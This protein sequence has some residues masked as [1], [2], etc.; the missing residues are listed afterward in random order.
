[1]FKLYTEE[2][3]TF[4]FQDYA[5]LMQQVKDLG[6]KSCLEF[7]PGY[8]TYALIEAGLDLIVTLE[9]DPEWYEISVRRFKEYPQVWVGHYQDEPEVT[10]DDLKP[11]DFDMAFVDS[12]KGNTFKVVGKDGQ[13]LPGIRKRHPG[14]EDCSR[15]N[16]CVKALEH[17]PVV[18]LHDAQR[19]L[20]RGTLG[21]LSAM[22]HKITQ[23]P[24]HQG[25]IARID[26]NGKDAAG[27]GLP[28]PL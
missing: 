13:P 24:A 11:G 18:F 7:G 23:L 9:H 17:A 27:S 3:S 22:G 25:C 28:S 16:T 6:A 20:E 21:R 10:T 14:Q 12:P 1:M 8:S 26:R 5:L 2:S 15:Y 4:R 19:P